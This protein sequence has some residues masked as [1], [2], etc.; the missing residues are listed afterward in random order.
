MRGGDGVFVENL[1][2]GGIA[3]VKF[4]AVPGGHADGAVLRVHLRHV[5]AAG[6]HIG[7]ADTVDA[8]TFGHRLAGLD[9]A[10]AGRHAVTGIN[11]AAA[12]A[13]GERQG[14]GAERNETQKAAERA[15]SPRPGHS[16]ACPRLQRSK[17]PERFKSSPNHRTATLPGTGVS[18]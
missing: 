2:V 4:V 11:F 10:G 5:S 18:W 17:E 12:G 15:V 1:A 13:A 14:A 7:L 16:A 8:A 3:A 6:D 9:H